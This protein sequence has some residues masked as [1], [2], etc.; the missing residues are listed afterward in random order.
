MQTNAQI[1]YNKIV[2]ISALL[3]GLVTLLLTDRYLVNYLVKPLGMLKN[4]LVA[5]RRQTE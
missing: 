4:H 1:S 5:D 3:A 2:L